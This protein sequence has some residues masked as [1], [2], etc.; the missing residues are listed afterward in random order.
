VGNNINGIFDGQLSNTG[1]NALMF[2]AQESGVLLYMEAPNKKEVESGVYFTKGDNISY[3]IDAGRLYGTNTDPTTFTDAQN[4]ANW[5]YIRDLT[6]T[7]ITVQS[8]YYSYATVIG[9]GNANTTFNLNDFKSNILTV[10]G[11]LNGYPSTGGKISIE[12]YESVTRSTVPGLLIDA[13]DNGYTWTNTSINTNNTL[14]TFSIAGILE[15]DGITLSGSSVPDD[16]IIMLHNL[17]DNPTKEEIEN[18]NHNVKYVYSDTTMFDN[19][20][21]HFTYTRMIQSDE[22][23]VEPVARIEA[24]GG[25]YNVL[26]DYLYFGTNDG[27]FLYGLVPKGSDNRRNGDDN[28]D[29]KYDPGDKKFHDIGSDIPHTWG[30][31]NTGA[32]LTSLPTPSNMETHYWYHEN[33]NFMFQFNN[34][35]Y[36]APEPE[37]VDEPDESFKRLVATGGTW[38]E[39]YDYFYFETTSEGRFLYGLVPKGTVDRNNGKKVWD[40]EYD[41]SNMKFYDVGDVNPDKWG[42][43]NTGT[44]ISTFP[45][46]PNMKTHYLYHENGNLYF[47]FDNPYYVEPPPEPD[48]SF[49]RLVAT[50]GQWNG[51]FEYLYFST[52][53]EGN[54]VY[55]LVETDSSDRYSPTIYDF[56]YNPSD[57]KFHDSGSSHPAKWGIDYN[58]NG[59]SEFPTTANMET[60]FWYND[61][62]DTLIFQFT[63]PYYV[64]PDEPVVEPVERIVI[65]DGAWEGSFDYLYMETT[66]EG[67]YLYGRVGKGST[68]M[69]GSDIRDVEYDPS[70]EKFHD[71]GTS[72]PATWSTDDTGTNLSDFPTNPNMQTHYWYDSNSSFKIKF[73][74]PYYVPPEPGYKYLAFYGRS[75]DSNGWF[76]ELELSTTNGLIDYRNPVPLNKITVVAPVLGNNYN[77]PSCIFDGQYTQT[78]SETFIFDGNVSGVLFYMDNSSNI[79]VQSGSYYTYD[80][81]GSSAIQSGNTYGTNT[82]PTTFVATD[83]ANWDYVCDL[84]IISYNPVDPPAPTYSYATIIATGIIEGINPGAYALTDFKWAINNG[85]LA[86]NVS[87]AQINSVDFDIR[88]AGTMNDADTEWDSAYQWS[89]IDEA[90]DNTLFTYAHDNIETVEEVH[91]YVYQRDHG[92]EHLKIILHNF[93]QNPTMDQIINSG[94]DIKIYYSDTSEYVN[95]TNKFTYGYTSSNGN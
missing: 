66:P 80:S 41:P 13:S 69:S 63:N 79:E 33:G 57:G 93:S 20:T 89:P 60:L 64:A 10:N 3:Q 56:E 46:D 9:I 19:E 6:K 1:K 23:V 39:S 52:T 36:V 47:Q 53:P 90:N 44:N 11:R 58:G 83:E 40:V 32:N 92:P 88:G 30:E 72:V 8:P 85:V 28:W 4:D 75:G 22:P 2:E 82:D 51:T 87:D 18:E 5:S 38:S 78:G 95:E 65:T 25:E 34:P 7:P 42:S 21:E 68:D 94:Q 61:S 27:R 54:F 49:K 43:D 37:P 70:D 48:E 62:A 77:N 17:H 31:D 71:V 14:F 67:R 55:G 35:Y 59:I 76:Y 73:D 24:T 12:G 50:G 91:L 15:V 74:N 81:Q 16:L 45:T 26:Y 29:V 84:T 86:H